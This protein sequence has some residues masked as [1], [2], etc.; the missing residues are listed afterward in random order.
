[1]KNGP[2]IKIS[3]KKYLLMDFFVNLR[4]LYNSNMPKVS[5]VKRSQN[6]IFVNVNPFFGP[7]PDF[8]IALKTAFFKIF[9]RARNG[10]SINKNH[11]LRPLYK[12]YFCHITIVKCTIG[13]TINSVENS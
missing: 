10:T 9:G 3:Q 8:E 2:K 12:K 11:V 1:M 7:T 5:I 13:C 4:P 6:M